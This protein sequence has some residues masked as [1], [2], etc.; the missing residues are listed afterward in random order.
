VIGDIHALVVTYNRRELVLR[1][2]DALLHQTHPLTSIIVIDNGGSDGTGEAIRA[3]AVNEPTI[4][5]V[6]VENNLGAA[7]G[8]NH[9]MDYAFGARKLD[10]VWIMDDDVIPSETSL[11]VLVEAYEHNFQHPEE[12]GFLVSQL[13]DGEGRANNV[14]TVDTRPR[15]VGE[16]ARWGLYLDQGIVAVRSAALTALLMPRTTY[17]SFGNLN[18]DFVVWGEDTELTFRIT[19]QRPGYI[20][21][22]SK[23]VHLRGQPGD[24]SIFLEDEP[25]RVP[26]FYYLYRNMVY[27]RR[28]YVGVHAYVNGIV[29]GVLEASQLAVS[30]KWWKAQI[31]LRGTMAGVVFNPKVPSLPRR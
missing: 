10:W 2:L 31:A 5:Y 16:C 6:R 15:Q 11:A 23:V 20:V 21:G 27:V 3:L 24:I 17:Q 19:E 25:S 9:G 18:P 29:R 12:V 13:V 8:F 1:S 14:P 7:G 22:R 4:D 30:G 26:N 28:R